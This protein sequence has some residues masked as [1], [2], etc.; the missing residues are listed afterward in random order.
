MIA[1]N[2]WL[3]VSLLGDR[4]GWLHSVTHPNNFES[5]FTLFPASKCSWFTFKLQGFTSF[6]LHPL[7][8]LSWPIWS[9]PQGRKENNSWLI[10]HNWK[11]N[12]QHK[13]REHHRKDFE[14]QG[15]H[16]S[17]VFSFIIVIFISSRTFHLKIK[18]TISNKDY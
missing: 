18:V 16:Q 9:T 1:N 17:R 4:R 15:N 6:S 11:V 13:T 3:E 10:S 8:L 5:C 7:L 2:S 14:Y 12:Y